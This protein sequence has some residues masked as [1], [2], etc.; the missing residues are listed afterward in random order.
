MAVVGAAIGIVGARFATRLLEHMLYGTS[1]TDPA[2]FVVGA[3]VLIGTA[4]VACLVP[5]RRAVAVDPLV[6]IRAD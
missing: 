5:V 6:S 2:S 3:F 4:I 1:P